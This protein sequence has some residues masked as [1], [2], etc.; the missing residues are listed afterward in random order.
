ML[1][2]NGVAVRTV[3][4]HEDAVLYLLPKQHFLELCQKYPEFADYFTST[5]GK[6]MMDRSYAA[7]VAKV[8][9]PSEETPGF[10]LTQ[11]I[12][13][14][15]NKEIIAC[16]MDATIQE[17]AIC[18][19]ESKRSS[20]LVKDARNRYIG[21]VTDRDF[22]QKVVAEGRDIHE[23][24]SSIMSSPLVTI[25]GNAP[26]FEAILL[27]VQKNIQ[28]L[29]VTNA[30]GKVIGVTSNKGLLMAQGQSP[31]LL[32]R[33]ILEATAPEELFGKQKKI[34]FF[35]K[36][37][38]RMGARADHLNRLITTVSDAIL[39]KLIQFALERLGEPPVRFVFLTLG[40]EGRKEQTLKTDQ[41]NAILYE[42]VPEADAIKV[43]KYFLD[44][45]EM[46][47]GWLDKAGYKYCNGG[48]MAQNPQW[49]QPLSIWKKYFRTWIH[50]PEPKAVMHSTIFFDFVGAFGDM[51]LADELRNYLFGLLDHRAG[52]FFY[53]L[54]NN[55]LNIKPPLGFFRNFV[56]ESKGEHRNALDIK[57]AMTPI[58]DF[59]RCYALEAKIEVTNT[60]ERLT[61]LYAEK[62]I[63]DKEYDELVQA[64]RYLMQLRLVRQ[65]KAV[66]N[67][68]QEPDNYINPKTLTHIE[69]KMLKE[70]FSLIGDYQQKLKV[71]F[72]GFA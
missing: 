59:A 32:I 39:K 25:P 16:G 21:I 34:S 29:A 54:A 11:S 64:Y 48:I 45:G 33:E 71:H 20:I 14:V 35:V 23:K 53:H 36:D 56:V 55:S 49:C 44:F 68:Q 47:C 69:Q 28:H 62:V 15:C 7:I 66:V 58:V 10:P 51:S 13:Q 52:V 1:I 67:E 38:V 43:Q 4:V 24:V 46:V 12:E 72:T 42:D 41:D 19:T 9:V 8:S 40:S 18:M 37:M 17:A 26:I 63:S 2:N 27:M 50:T 65:V 60:L 70:I 30:R 31:V 57:K 61:R 3:R 6:R 22:R 5:F